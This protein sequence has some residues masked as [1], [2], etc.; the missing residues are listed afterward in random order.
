MITVIQTPDAGDDFTGT[1]VAGLVT[2]VDLPIPANNPDLVPICTII[3]LENLLA[4]AI[5]TVDCFFVRPGQPLTTTQRVTVRNVVDNRG[6]SLAGCRIPIPGFVRGSAGV[7][8]PWPLVLIT[9]GKALIASFVV[10]Y[11]LGKAI[12]GS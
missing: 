7:F 5:P 4:E 1:G 8:T 2:F 10:S 11:Q 9:T 6:F 3:A 12:E